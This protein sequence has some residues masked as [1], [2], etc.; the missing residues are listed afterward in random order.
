MIE[1]SNMPDHL[2][3]KCNGEVL[4]MQNF[5]QLSPITNFSDQRINFNSARIFQNHSIFLKT[6]KSIM[7]V[8]HRQCLEDRPI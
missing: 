3:K 4:L 7:Q 2:I 1:D 6:E 5:P 8:I